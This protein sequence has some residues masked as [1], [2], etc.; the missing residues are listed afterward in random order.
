VST[1]LA[2]HGLRGGTGVSTLL[3]GLA[4]AL[5]AL[6]QRVLVVDMSPDN[7]LGLHFNLPFVEPT[8]WARAQVEGGDWRDAA[9]AVE[10]GLIVVPY[11]RLDLD[12]ISSVEQDLA[13][14]PELWG[15]R[16]DA[17]SAGV[18]WLLFDVPSHLPGHAAAILRHARCD[19]GL[20]VVNVDSGCHALL[21]RPELRDRAQD[22]LLVNRYDPGRQLQRDLMQLWLHQFD[23]RLVPQPVHE[24]GSAPEAL[25]S[26]L[27]IRRHAPASLAAADLD[28]LAVWCLTRSNPGTDEVRG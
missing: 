26:K 14:C 1:V 15:Q 9:F 5:H 4:D 27:P 28:S 11:G 20:Q 19:I 13:A 22:W 25:A 18:D 21:Q 8:G 12:G 24:D 10:D 7:L 17:L 3:A 23:A 6:Q 2:M 16:I